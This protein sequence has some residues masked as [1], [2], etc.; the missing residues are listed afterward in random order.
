MSDAW[1]VLFIGLWVVCIA[2]ATLVVGL[3][4]RIQSLESKVFADGATGAHAEATAQLR[5]QLL[6]TQVAETAVESGVVGA[7]GGM[8]GV[9]LF[10]S[11][12]CGPCQALASDLSAKLTKLGK[13][14]GNGL[15]QLLGA[16]VTVVTD[17]AGA[18][19]KLATALIVDSDGAVMNDFA[20]TATPTGIAL[21]DEGVITEALIPNEFRDVERLAQAVQPGRLG[22]VMP[23]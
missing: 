1:L 10:V 3:S 19:D 17:Q 6:G 18:F 4:R 11:K 12:Q 13:S 8:A 20:V 7:A 14:K 16:R 23:P 9:V 5:E 21:N 22:V 2:L 15:A